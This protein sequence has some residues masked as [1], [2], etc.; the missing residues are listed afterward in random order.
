MTIPY[1]STVR[2]I[3]NQLKSDFFEYIGK[4]DNK[5]AYKIV[6]E[7]YKNTSAELYLNNSEIHCL[8]TII[9]DILYDTFPILKELVSYLKD[10]NKTLKDLNLAPI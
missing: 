3:S 9:H 4:I 10:M 2:G 7:T 5:V 1:G 6:D 8:A